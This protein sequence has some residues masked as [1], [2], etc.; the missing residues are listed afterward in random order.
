MRNDTAQWPAPLP[1]DLYWQAGGLSLNRL[2]PARQTLI[3][4]MDV[5]EAFGPAT[6]WPERAEGDSYT[7][8]LRRDRV[9]RVNGP[10]MAE[11]WNAQTAR[12]VTDMTEGYALFELR[13]E[14]CGD[15]L[16]RGAEMLPSRSAMRLWA[17]LEVI[18]Y[19]HGTDGTVRIHIARARADSV[20]DTIQR[21]H[22][23]MI[24]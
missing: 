15:L 22:A 12:A 16:L 23:A 3:S 6:G 13:G 19:H 18:L 8:A 10:E 20:V 17:G 14:R 7:V 2:P 4:G 21:R 11:G 9:L 1:S 24:R 5:L